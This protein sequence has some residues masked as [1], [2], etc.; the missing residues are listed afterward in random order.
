MLSHKP[1]LIRAFYD[2]V[3]DSNATPYIAVDTTITGCVIPPDCRQQ[4]QVV[5]D[6]SGGAA[7]ALALGDAYVEFDSRFSGA[8]HHVRVPVEAVL[9]V[10]AHENGAGILFLEDNAVSL[11]EPDDE[12]AVVEESTSTKKHGPAKLSVVSVNPKA[13]RDDRKKDD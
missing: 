8:R 12:W 11:I 4:P 5:F 6:L 7:H 10:Y 9:A 2:W 1:Y 13:A 3:V